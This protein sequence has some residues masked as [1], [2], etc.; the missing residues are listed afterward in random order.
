MEEKYALRCGNVIIKLI[1]IYCMFYQL[2]INCI[3]FIVYRAE[4]CTMV[5]T[6]RQIILPDLG[7]LHH[8]VV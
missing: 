5:P 2:V 3:H 8:R 4:I 6:K 1:F 7:Y